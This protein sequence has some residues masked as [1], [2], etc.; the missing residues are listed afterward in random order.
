MNEDLGAQRRQGINTSNGEG[1]F[2]RVC[3]QT[4]KYQSAMGLHQEET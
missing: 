4:D 3:S 2:E 1:D